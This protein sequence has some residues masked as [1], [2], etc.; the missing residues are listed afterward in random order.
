[1]SSHKAKIYVGYV[2]P[3]RTHN[4]LD[5]VYLSFV[6]FH[7][8]KKLFYLSINCTESIDSSA[9]VVQDV[10][11]GETSESVHDLPIEN[12]NEEESK[13]D[14]E[15]HDSEVRPNVVPSADEQP[16]GYQVLKI[17]SEPTR[18]RPSEEPKRDTNETS[19]ARK[20]YSS[21]RIRA[22]NHPD[23]IAEARQSSTRGRAS[24]RT[25]S[26][27]APEE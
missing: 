3:G 17:S 14:S 15:Q 25:S 24:R 18:K 5:E 4:L 12:K 27:K 16:R 2:S 19:S 7:K 20:K 21:L 9:R 8:D 1:M 6:P 11:V 23:V 13:R 22:S 10:N 26:S